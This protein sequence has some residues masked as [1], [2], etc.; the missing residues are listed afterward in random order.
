VEL[1][2]LLLT[3]AG[4]VGRGGTLYFG[5]SAAECRC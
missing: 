3:A 5:R 1:N 2:G 4:V